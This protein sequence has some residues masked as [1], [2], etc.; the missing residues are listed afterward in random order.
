MVDKK[1]ILCKRG[2]IFLCSIDGTLILD[3]CST[4]VCIELYVY[5]T[6]DKEEE[7]MFECVYRVEGWSQRK[8][9]MTH[10]CA[11]AIYLDARFAEKAKG[12]LW[13]H[14][15][16]VLVRA[17]IREIVGYEYAQVN[18]WGNTAFLANMSVQGNYACLGVDG[19]LLE[20]DWSHEKRITYHTHNVD[21]KSQAFDLLTIFTSWI[22]MVEANFS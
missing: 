7:S 3:L 11:F 18:F 16:Q 1:L 17:R 21:T 22:D 6:I 10:A 5:K 14:E 12:L 19:M 9:I 13:D 15:R 20:Q 8:D 2:L 4:G